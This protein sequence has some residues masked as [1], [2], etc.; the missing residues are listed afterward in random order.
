MGELIN[1]ELFATRFAVTKAGRMNYYIALPYVD[2]FTIGQ[3]LYFFMMQTAYVGELLNIDT[4]NQPGV[5][6]GKNATYALMGRKGY[7]KKKEEL[8]GAPLP[9]ESFVI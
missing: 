5:E 8:D 7:E 2:E 4:Y 3:L 1:T 6:E 9:E